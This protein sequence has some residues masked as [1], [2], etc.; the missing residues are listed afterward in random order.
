VPPLFQS[1]D[2]CWREA[3][4]FGVAASRSVRSGTCKATHRALLADTIPA[5]AL[6]RRGLMHRKLGQLPEAMADFTALIDADRGN[7]DA[8]NARARTLLGVQRR[9]DQPN[10][11]HSKHL[12]YTRSFGERACRISLQA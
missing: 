11:Q 7:S 2:L 10:A 9:L 4:V 12:L 5:T 3:G 1:P 6:R 8:H